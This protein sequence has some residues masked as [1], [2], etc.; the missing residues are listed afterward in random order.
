MKVQFL[1]MHYYILYVHA[2]VPYYAF[3]WFQVN[4]YNLEILVSKGMSND[5][6]FVLSGKC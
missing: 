4:G 6:H 1:N 3:L 2:N 5:C